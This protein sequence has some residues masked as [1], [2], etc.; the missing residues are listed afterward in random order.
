MRAVIFF[1]LINNNSL[2][3]A[4]LETRVLTTS[5]PIFAG[6]LKPAINVKIYLIKRLR[7]DTFILTIFTTRQNYVYII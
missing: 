6:N 2:L 4:A 7:I 1:M 3:L 5:V